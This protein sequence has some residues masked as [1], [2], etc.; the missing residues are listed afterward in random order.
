MDPFLHEW[1]SLLLR[2]LHVVAGMAWIGASFYF[3]HLD[4]S[5]RAEPRL[6]PGTA[7]EAWEVHGGGFYQVRKWKVAPAELPPHLTWH[8]WQAYATWT[9]GFALLCWI[10]YGHSELYLIDPAIRDLGPLA[11]SGIGIGGLVLGW[12]VYDALCRSPLGRNDVALGVVGFVFIVALAYGFQLVFSGRGAL[13][14]TGAVM[15]TI[16]G[17]NV[18]MNI[19][20][21]QRRVV[22][23]L[24]A[25]R[26][27]DPAIGAAA[28]QRST[29]N[30][31]LTLPVVFLMLSGHAPLVTGTPHAWAVVALVLVA[32]ALI[33]VFYNVWNTGRGAPWWTWGA[34]AAAIALAA[35][36]SLYAAPLGRQRLGLP[37]AAEAAPPPAAALPPEQ[38]TQIVLGRCSMCHMPAPVWEGM[39]VPPKGVVLHTPEHIARQR[40]AIQVQS[41]L[42]NAMPPNNV[43]H[44][45]PEERAVLAAWAAR[46]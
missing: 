37:E 34:A 29:H 46:H 16:M 12:V 5:L 15:A 41:V 28:K 36:L 42:S 20:P 13:I 9:S 14:H 7:G 18:A 31:Y 23:D 26:A 45:Q 10:Y 4:A 2:W 19:I 40:V 44:L 21:G 43:T 32:G 11:A 33:R 24:I 27:P 17:A 39:A 22:A 38:V 3:M 35:F 1:G 30:N 25:G 8:K 6:P